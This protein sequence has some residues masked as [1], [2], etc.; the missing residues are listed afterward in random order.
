MPPPDVFTAPA[1]LSAIEADECVPATWRPAD[2]AAAAF[3][4]HALGMSEG[5]AAFVFRALAV[6]NVRNVRAYV[7]PW[8]AHDVNKWEVEAAQ[9]ATEAGRRAR[10]TVGLHR[11]PDPLIRGL[12][13]RA[14]RWPDWRVSSGQAHPLSGGA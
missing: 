14:V 13:R 2:I 4:M 1:V 8:T 9:I 3:H 6:Q 5:L 12:R 11:D 7:T 10:A